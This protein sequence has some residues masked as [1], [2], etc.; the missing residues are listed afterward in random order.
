VL[1]G[2]VATDDPEGQEIFESLRAGRRIL[3]FSKTRRWSLCS[4]G[5]PSW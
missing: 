3:S 4:D 1:V 2:N 5:P